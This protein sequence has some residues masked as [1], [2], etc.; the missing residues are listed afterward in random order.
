MNI[1]WSCK[2]SIE[3][4]SHDPVE[5][6]KGIL[7]NNRLHRFDEDSI[8]YDANATAVVNQ[9]EIFLT[10]ELADAEYRKQCL[11][12]AQWYENQAKYYRQEA[13]NTS[14]THQD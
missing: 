6:W 10:K 1:Y 8:D 5:P 7:I 2:P 11:E 4:K 13:E 14:E 3:S 9:N 12:S